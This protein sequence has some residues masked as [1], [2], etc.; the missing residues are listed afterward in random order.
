MRWTVN[1]AAIRMFRIVQC[2]H[3]DSRQEIGTLPTRQS[4]LRSECVELT[5]CLSLFLAEW[6]GSSIHL[7]A[8]CMLELEVG[9]APQNAEALT[10]GLWGDCRFDAPSPRINSFRG[11]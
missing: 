5:P 7:P 10:S 1:A 3:C 2:Q 9:G 6:P 11:F 4:L 8:D